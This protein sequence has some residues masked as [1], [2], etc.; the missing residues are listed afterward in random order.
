MCRALAIVGLLLGGCVES[1]PARV[2]VGFDAS[3]GSRHDLDGDYADLG[4][5]LVGASGAERRFSVRSVGS[6]DAEALAGL[7]VLVVANPEVDPGISAAEEEAL[8]RWVREGGALWVI[9]DHAPYPRVVAGALGRFGVRVHDGWVHWTDEPLA[10]VLSTDD[11]SLRG[12]PVTDG[13]HGRVHALHPAG[14]SAFELSGGEVVAAVPEGWGV[15]L[16]AESGFV[17]TGSPAMIA[18]VEAGEG[19]VLVISEASMLACRRDRHGDWLG[20]CQP[21]REDHVVFARNAIEWLAGR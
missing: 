5:E 3:H 1:E 19:R 16:P 9:M 7:D 4:E 12:H 6:L 14:G 11:G 18:A 2:V 17:D 20:L 15:W 10:L 21:G 8:E 13:P